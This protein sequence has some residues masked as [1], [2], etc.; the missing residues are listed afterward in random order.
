MVSAQL[1]GVSDMQPFPGSAEVLSADALAAEGGDL[2][3]P[4]L[5]PRL[6]PNT[7]PVSPG[8]IEKSASLL[9]SLSFA[10]ARP[11]TKAETPAERGRAFA[12]VG[13][14]LRH[15]LQSDQM[16]R[17]RSAAPELGPRVQAALM[18][19]CGALLSSADSDAGFE[20]ATAEL[21]ELSKNVPPATSAVFP[22]AYYHEIF[23]SDVAELGRSLAAR[24][25][26]E[27]QKRA[28]AAD[29]LAVLARPGVGAAEVLGISR[30]CD[31]VG[32]IAEAAAARSMGELIE[33]EERARLAHEAV[34]SEAREARRV[35]KEAEAVGAREARACADEKRRRE[36]LQDEL[37]GVRSAMALEEET[38][39][40]V[41]AAQVRTME[42]MRSHEEA[43]WEATEKL[44]RETVRCAELEAAARR[45]G[46]EMTTRVEAAEAR[47]S[48]AGAEASK[49]HKQYVEA[50]KM[51][52]ALGG[53]VSALDSVKAQIEQQL[54]LEREACAVELGLRQ[55]AEAAH[56]AAQQS[57]ADA[58]QAAADA[59][60][61]AD[62]AKIALEQATTEL[63]ACEERLRVANDGS[64]DQQMA[65]AS[66]EESVKQ[67]K[68]LRTED[69]NKMQRLITEKATLEQKVADVESALA[70][71]QVNTDRTS[72]DAQKQ[73][74]ELHE[75]LTKLHRHC[76]D[77]QAKATRA[78]LL[79]QH[80]RE[81]GLT[82]SDH[83]KR[84]TEQLDTERRSKQALTQQLAAEA[85]LR[86]KSD[87][88]EGNR[89]KE[90]L[91]RD[92]ENALG[93]QRVQSLTSELHRSREEA[94][95]AREALADA[96]S[97]ALR[98][99][100]ERDA[101]REDARRERSRRD[102]LE[103]QAPPAKKSAP[104]PLASSMDP[105]GPAGP[106]LQ[107]NLTMPAGIAPP[108]P[109]REPNE[110]NVPNEELSRS[111]LWNF[112]NG[113]LSRAPTKV[114]G[115]SAGG[116]PESSSLPRIRSPFN[117]SSK[118]NEISNNAIGLA[119]TSLAPEEARALY[120]VAMAVPGVGDE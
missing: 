75:Q 115:G 13:S 59:T 86:Q 25:R 17:L 34:A 28:L 21:D 81:T 110:R 39:R 120:G 64:L 61:A 100:R 36:Q 23:A 49:A 80:E 55:K 35:V 44:Q 66:A 108:P 76:E 70:S 95:Q 79:L 105:R 45:A 67:L 15:E 119:P 74:Y 20:W 18:A 14:A 24:R 78:E 104:R 71:A 19:A 58:T 47:E 4:A 96:R 77:L 2:I 50:E 83:E 56:A 1:Y 113:A 42:E 93:A 8:T 5:L 99:E 112:S 101:E 32:L 31:D 52:V 69:A 43:R 103:A 3:A 109:A 102:Q 107:Q 7:R 60:Q 46:E 40:R 65:S 73:R 106:S 38:R 72:T 29:V 62:V 30:A 37:S 117:T 63:A 57:A 98:L 87:A 68:V 89:S 41:E 114:L 118:T 26:E 92:R 51:R 53:R 27:A 111:D 33:R 85:A 11:A 82:A 84:L 91:A 6:P 48:K 16:A 10:A 22:G 12:A 9:R 90:L 94:R 97:V 116:P 88:S 54:A